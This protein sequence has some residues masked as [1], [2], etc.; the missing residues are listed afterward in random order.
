MGDK[1]SDKV[2]RYSAD[3][4]CPEEVDFDFPPTAVEP[5]H[6][7]KADEDVLVLDFLDGDREN[8]FNWS[9]SRKGLFPSSSAS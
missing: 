1:D 3:R 4:G 9:P 5:R 7:E 8:P 2:E 6:L